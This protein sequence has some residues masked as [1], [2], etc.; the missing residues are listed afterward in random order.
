MQ[1]IDPFR[2]VLDVN[3][4]RCNVDGRITFQVIFRERHRQKVDAS[5]F[6]VESE[7]DRVENDAKGL[8][9]VEICNQGHRNTFWRW[10]HD[11]RRNNRKICLVDQI[12]CDGRKDDEEAFCKSELIPNML[13]LNRR[14]VWSSHGAVS[15]PER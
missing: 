8:W 14:G 5:F 2:H 6:I 11:G 10:V 7:V 12:L 9:D 3:G 13:A 4:L 15:F 1:E